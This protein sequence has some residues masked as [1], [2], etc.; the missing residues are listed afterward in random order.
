VM[1]LRK[2][3]APERLPPLST[4]AATWTGAEA[5]RIKANQPSRRFQ[6]RCKRSSVMNGLIIRAYG[7]GSGPSSLLVG[8]GPS[9]RLSDSQ[10]NRGT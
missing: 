4:M 8:I 1:V 10:G 9:T 3:T 5:A 2:E 7:Q 6:G